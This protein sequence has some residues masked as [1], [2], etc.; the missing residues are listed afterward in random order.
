[1]PAPVTTVDV[2]QQYLVGVVARADHHADNVNEVVL[3]LAG[4]YR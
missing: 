2:L 1:M 4:R 3:S